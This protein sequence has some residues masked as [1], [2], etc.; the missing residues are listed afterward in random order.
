MVLA[1]GPDEFLVIGSGVIVT[2]EPSGPSNDRAGILF[3]DELVVESGRIVV[4]RRLK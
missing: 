3:I 2:F 1:V 4:G